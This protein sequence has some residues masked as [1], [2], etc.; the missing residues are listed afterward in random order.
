MANTKISENTL[1]VVVT[2]NRRELLRRCILFLQKQT[3]LNLEILV[4]I[5][6]STD[7]TKEMLKE[8][9]LI[10][11]EQENLG[12]A[13]GFQRGID[14]ACKHN[15]KYCWLMD[16]DGYPHFQALEK[17]EDKNYLKSQTLFL[18]NSQNDKSGYRILSLFGLAEANFKDGKIDE[19]YTITSKK[20]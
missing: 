17:L 11:I 10:T 12:A 19:I 18:K 7:G 8:F 16:D 3:N 5:N 9:N 2:Y 6:G 4:V 13:A 15:F 20:T 1:A 14:F